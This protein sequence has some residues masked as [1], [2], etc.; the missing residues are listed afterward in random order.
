VLSRRH[1]KLIHSYG[2]IYETSNPAREY[3]LDDF[4]TLNL[5]KL[6]RFNHIRGTGLEELEAEWK[7]SD[8]EAMGSDSDDE[9][10]ESEDEGEEG[11]EM[12]GVED[13]E[14]D[15]DAKARR[16]AALSQAEKVRD[17]R[18]RCLQIVGLTFRKPC[19]NRQRSTWASPRTR[20][21]LWKMCCLRR[22]PARICGS[23]TTV[24]VGGYISA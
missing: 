21:G 2:G 10:S 22:C 17:G 5:E 20:T 24:H 7:G 19:G 8:D 12:D 4:V 6:D 14:D 15:E 1:C 18:Y 11:D 23:S 13:E 3:T 16:H 9:E